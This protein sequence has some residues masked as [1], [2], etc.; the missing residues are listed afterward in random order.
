MTDSCRYT[1]SD[2]EMDLLEWEEMDGIGL[3]I[4]VFPSLFP[5]CIS[6]RTSPLANEETSRDEPAYDLDGLLKGF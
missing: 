6:I 5:L 1:V 3:M 4:L 2:D